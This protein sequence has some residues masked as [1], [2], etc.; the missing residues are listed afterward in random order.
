MEKHCLMLTRILFTLGLVVQRTIGV[1]PTVTQADFAVT[2]GTESAGNTYGP[3]DVTL[4]VPDAATVEDYT[5]YIF[6]DNAAPPSCEFNRDSTATSVLNPSTPTFTNSFSY[7]WIAEALSSPYPSEGVCDVAAVNSSHVIMKVMVVEGI[8]F[9]AEDKVFNIICEYQPASIGTGTVNVN[10]DPLDSTD[11]VGATGTPN[12]LDRNYVLSMHIDATDDP[13]ASTVTIGTDVY[14]R[15]SMSGVDSGAG[16]DGDE[17]AVRVDSCIATDDAITNTVN[18]ITNRCRD[19][20][21][22]IIWQDPYNALDRLGF[23]TDNTGA[24]SVSPAFEMFAITGGNTKNIVSFSCNVEVC[25]ILADCQGDNCPSKRR[26]RDFLRLA[27]VD[28]Y[29]RSSSATAGHVMLSTSVRIQ[30]DAEIVK[31][32]SDPNQS[33]TSVASVSTHSMLAMILGMITGLYSQV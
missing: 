7:N 2:C 26:K 27:G 15:V 4:T 10:N 33:G 20:T 16:A 14:L 31:T 11:N 17:N 12:V 22:E 19:V 3:I 25:R 28:R 29:R 30:D 6:S 13:V 24:L 21:T 5:V 8:L 9:T 18:L 1:P 32:T 23:F